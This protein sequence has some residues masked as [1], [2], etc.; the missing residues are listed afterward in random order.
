MKLIDEAVEVAFPM[1]GQI[2]YNELAKQVGAELSEKGNVITN[3]KGESSIPN[4][5]VAG[6]L[7]QGKKYQIYTAWDMAVDSVDDMD[8]KLRKNI[9]NKL[10]QKPLANK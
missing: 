9:E 8:A 3:E 7:R 5:Y 4:F 10:N 6:D 2:A 1:L